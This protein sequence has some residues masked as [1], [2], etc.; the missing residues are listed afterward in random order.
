MMI[1]DIH[2]YA[3]QVAAELTASTCSQPFTS[4]CDVYK[5]FNKIYLMIYFLNNQPVV[6]LKVSPQHGEMLRD[7]YSF[8][9]TGYHM[10]K[11]HWITLYTHPDLSKEL[12]HELIYN[13][14][15]LV[16]SKLNKNQKQQLTILKSISSHIK[17]DQ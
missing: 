8:I 9:H 4:E 17:K 11:Q 15:T 1:L 16:C 5:V 6:N 3:K 10:N 7:F 14:Y 12:L 13:S 2:N